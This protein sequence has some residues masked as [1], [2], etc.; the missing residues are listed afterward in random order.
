MGHPAKQKQLG[1]QYKIGFQT[2]IEQA[3]KYYS[4]GR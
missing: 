2:G 4:Q 1:F 3:L